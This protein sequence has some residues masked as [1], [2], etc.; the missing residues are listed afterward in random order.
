[1]KKLVVLTLLVALA[2]LSACTLGENEMKNTEI[3]DDQEINMS[4]LQTA[5]FAGGCFWCIEAAFQQQPGVADAVSGYTGGNDTD[6]DYYEVASGDTGHYEAVEVRFDPDIIPYE[7]LLE[8]FF[9]QIDPTDDTGQFADRGSEYTTAIFYHNESQRI[10]AEN[11]K[12]MLNDSGYY[13]KPI[14]TKVLPAQN[15]YKAE[16]E[17][18]DYFLKQKAHYGTYKVLSGRAGY[19]DK[20]KEAVSE[21]LTE[22]EKMT[23]KTDTKEY[24]KPSDAKIKEMLTPLQYSVTQENGTE[25]AFNNEYWNNTE[26]GIYVDIVSGEPLFS[27]TDKYKSGTGWPS[28]TKPLV[29]ENII[30]NKDFK[31]IVPRTEVR[32]KNGDSHLGHV[33]SD[34]PEPTG[35]RFCMNSAALRFIPK[36]KMEEEGYGEFLYLFE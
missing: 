15:F 24:S 19:I 14:V 11:A 10:A 12:K 28:F 1:M 8:I 35:Q 26:E 2:L 23:A 4:N 13:K 7:K 18:Q 21:T 27:S 3:A 32:S 16:E 31:L 33:F 17:H 22:D 5:T 34:G 9:Q 25:R 6:P 20:N 29:P 36:D 30:E